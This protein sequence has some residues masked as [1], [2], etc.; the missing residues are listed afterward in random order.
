MTARR[1][2]AASSRPKPVKMR[3]R[4]WPESACSAAGSRYPSSSP[5]ADPPVRA[6]ANHRSGRPT[7]RSP[8]RHGQGRSMRRSTRS[9]PEMAGGVNDSSEEI[10]VRG[11][12]QPR[13]IAIQ[14]PRLLAGRESRAAGQ[15]AP[16][17]E[18]A[19][20]TALS[21]LAS[22]NRQPAGSPPRSA[23][24]RSM[25]TSPCAL[26]PMKATGRTPART[27]PMRMTGVSESAPL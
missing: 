1:P 6:A 21:R 10:S 14:E 5:G 19:A 11:P 22:R 7:P 18:A 23:S 3:A 27:F 2:A 24:A 20:G 15:P 4:C 25:N 16:S 26:L 17:A 9:G 13:V 8:P 12:P